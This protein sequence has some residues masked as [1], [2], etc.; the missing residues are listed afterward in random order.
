MRLDSLFKVEICKNPISK[1]YVEE[2]PGNTPYVTTTS[3]NN[4]VDGYVDYPAQYPGNVI[5]VSKDG[6]SAD[7]FLQ[8]D[9]FCGNE[10]VMVLTPL[11]ELSK[12]EL[13]YYTAVISY[14][15]YRFAYGRKCSV[16]RLIA[17]EIPSI[18]DIPT[19]IDSICIEPITTSN[20]NIQT[21]IDV[22][23]WQEF[24]LNELFNL[25]GGFYNKK[26]EHSVEG[27]IPFLGS[28]ENNNG[29]TEF[30]SLDDIVQWS[31]TGEEEFLLG[32]KLFLGNCIVVTVDG[33]VC[34]AYYQEEQ[35]TCSHSVTALYIK[36]HKMSVYLA[37]FICSIIMQDKYRWSYGRKPHDVE[38]F[39]KSIIKLP[40]KY[41]SDGTVFI[42]KNKGYSSNGYVPDWDYME[43][44]IKSLPYGDRI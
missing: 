7:A 2:N 12:T 19:W 4:G 10:K 44:Y 22:S 26:P 38:K 31:K 20:K 30:Y 37:M 11:K 17:L 9:P 3:E 15:K 24:K 28:T 18:E 36:N 23:N 6:A 16:E 41:N 35:F 43:N 27:G 14:N 25:K 29:V 34:N 40:V 39:G 33:S 21:T 8:P 1:S 13:M 42:D 5:T 32:E